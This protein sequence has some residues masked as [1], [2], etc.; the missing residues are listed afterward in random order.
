MRANRAK[1]VKGLDLTCGSQVPE[2]EDCWKLIVHTTKARAVA[3]L[4]YVFFSLALASAASGT[5]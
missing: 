1:P 5:G 2:A 3:A 4:L